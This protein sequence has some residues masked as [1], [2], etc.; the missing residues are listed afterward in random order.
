MLLQPK[1]VGLTA[2]IIGFF[3]LSIVGSIVGLSPYTCCKRAL[4]GALITYW[5]ASTATH[6]VNLIL[7]RA[8][9]ASQ[10]DKD[11]PGDNED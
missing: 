7:T 1:S 9:I 11:R 4:L 8:M 2:A 6:A 10:M 5:A 3:G